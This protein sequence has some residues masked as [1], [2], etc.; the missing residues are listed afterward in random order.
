MSNFPLNVVDLGVL[1]VILLSALIA[2]SRGLVREILSIGAWVA[3]ALAT[4]YGLPRLQDIARAYI[5]SEAIADAATGVTIFVVTLFVCAALGHLLARKMHASGLGAVDRSLG[6][7]FGVARGAILVCLAYLA[8]IWAMPKEDDQPD[9][10]KKAHTLRY[11]KQG[12]EILNSLLPQ[13]ARERSAAAAAE[14]KTQVEQALTNQMMPTVAPDP[15]KLA[16][17]ANDPGYNANER[18]DLDRLIKSN[19]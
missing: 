3:A 4:I 19:E 8:F 10:V 5:K 12:A 17:P 1:G 11:V 14:V 18:K 13:G 2:F 7:L 16:A 9:L 15:S 6:L